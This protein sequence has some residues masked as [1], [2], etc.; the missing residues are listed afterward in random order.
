[1]KGSHNKL[2]VHLQVLQVSGLF[3]PIS[4]ANLVWASS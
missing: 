3:E 2:A 1:M 4:A